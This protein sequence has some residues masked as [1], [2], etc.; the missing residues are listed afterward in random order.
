MKIIV[1]R[2]EDM[3]QVFTMKDAI[4]ADKEALARCV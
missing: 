1:L 2:E 3:N 4:Q